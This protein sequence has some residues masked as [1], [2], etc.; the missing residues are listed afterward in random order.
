MARLSPAPQPREPERTA[1]PPSYL[2]CASL[3]R[4][5]DVAE[6]TVRDLVNRGILPPPLALGGRARW[7]WA[8]VVTALNSLKPGAS[9]AETDP[10]LEGVRNAK[11]DK[12]G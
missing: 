6:S 10:Y 7:C 12:T 2:S 8:D 9:A 11:K 5:L 4:E 1:R 3:A